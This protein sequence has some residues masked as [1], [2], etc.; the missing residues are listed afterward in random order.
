MSETE[1]TMLDRVHQRYSQTNPGNGPRYTVAEHVRLYPGFAGYGRKERM[2]TADA[3][4]VDAWA[5]SGHLVHGIEVKCSRSDWLT[6]LK[7][8]SKAD[9]WRP[10]VD[11]W[12]VAVSD[13]SIVRAG[14]LPADWG[15]LVPFTTPST[16]LQR[17]PRV[18]GPAASLKV[19]KQAPYIGK[20]Q[21]PFE[22][23]VT[24]GKAVR[25]T[26]ERRLVP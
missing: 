18:Y 23:V 6:E 9:A 1:R 24:Y 22:L 8:L 20:S 10:Y 26:T 2:R 13:P 5:S 4:V 19:R 7:D 12:W 11:H 21:W 3:L 15:L 14:E 17:R 16:L 25:R